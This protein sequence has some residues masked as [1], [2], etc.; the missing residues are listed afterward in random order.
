MTLEEL[1]RALDTILR[2]FKDPYR[3]A[4]DVEFDGMKVQAAC[5]LHLEEPKTF[6][7]LSAPGLKL[8]SSIACDHVLF[9]LEENCTAVVVQ[10]MVRLLE[11]AEKAYLQ[12]DK[13]HAYSMFSIAVLTNTA[14]AEAI[15]LLKKHRGVRKY[16]HGWG[17]F[18][19]AVV[20]VATQK[21]VC[22]RD[23]KEF[24][25]LILDKMKEER[26]R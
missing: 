1:T 4:L 15:K 3:T 14:T 10:R 17:A 26:E 12:P 6:M 13:N 20:D 23:G 18:R 9:L 25:R 24:G 21:A 5:S 19:L 16:K 7:G 8:G 2:T 22:N 11:A